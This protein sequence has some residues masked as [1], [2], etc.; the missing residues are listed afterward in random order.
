MS[1]VKVS[2]FRSTISLLNYW[3]SVR[4]IQKSLTDQLYTVHLRV[5]SIIDPETQKMDNNLS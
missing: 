5:S 4:N 1:E 2:G 3:S